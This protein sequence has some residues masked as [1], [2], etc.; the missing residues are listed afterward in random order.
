MIYQVYDTDV[1]I[2]ILHR[3]KA[4]ELFPS[5]V[6]SMILKDDKCTKHNSGV[7][8]QDMYVDPYTNIS[9]ID[10]KDA[11]NFGFFKIDFLT[12]TFY[13]GVKDE[14]HLVKL[15][16]EEPDWDLL[17][18]EE[19]VSN[20]FQISNYYNLIVQKKPKS[21]EELA[22]FIALLRPGK[23]QYKNL[24][25]EEISKVIWVKDNNEKYHFKKSHSIA[26][27]TVIVVQLNLLKDLTSA[28]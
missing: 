7:Y 13:E 28:S 22:M 10:Y 14:K 11:E 23:A 3:D 19:V 4:L 27:A 8:F 20:L 9:T 25:W 6:P 12:N 1:D 26:Y 21:V 2:D 15:I 17:M 5:A 18:Y 24:T 16:N